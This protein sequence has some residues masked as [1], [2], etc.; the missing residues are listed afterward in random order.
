MK[1]VLSVLQL[2][3]PFSFLVTEV[4]MKDPVPCAAHAMA[5]LLP[6]V[7]ESARRKQLYS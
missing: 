4:L 7:L 6:T 3:A 5:V 2:K 1:L